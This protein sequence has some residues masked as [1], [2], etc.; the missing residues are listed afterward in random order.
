MPEAVDDVFE[1]VYSPRKVEF[2]LH[3]W[4]E[5]DTLVHSPKSSAHIAEHLNREWILL[6]VRLRTCLCQEAHAVDSRA[7][8]PACA[9]MPS[10]GGSFNAGSET[11][12]C[13]MADLRRAADTLPPTWLSTRQIWVEQGLDAR[14]IAQRVQRSRYAPRVAEPAYSRWVAIRHMAMKLG[15]MPQ[16]AQL[17]EVA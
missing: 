15:W 11:V 17:E 13:V 9:H 5:L 10:G 16:A 4:E 6:Q 14:L 8:D 3:H 2:W 12:R 7:V 1:P